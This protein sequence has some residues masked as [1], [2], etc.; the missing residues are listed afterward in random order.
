MLRECSCDFQRQAALPH[1]DEELPLSVALHGLVGQPHVARTT[2]GEPDM[3]QYPPNNKCE[4]C[5]SGGS[6]SRG[7][8]G[9]GQDQTRANTYHG[10]T[11]A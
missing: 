5:V 11:V 6:P 10:D 9:G 4:A 7:N 2:F 8:A 1:F 3:E